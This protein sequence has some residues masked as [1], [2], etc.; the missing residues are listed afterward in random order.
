[1]H[2]EVMARFEKLHLG[3]GVYVDIEAGMV[4]LT[5]EN[6]Y[7]A[8]NTIYLELPVYEALVKY[9]ELVKASAAESKEDVG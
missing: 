2:V 7:E 9:V 8:T 3:D 5:T 4:K 6:G 1:M